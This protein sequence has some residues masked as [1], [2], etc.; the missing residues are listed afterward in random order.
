[1]LDH[2]AYPARRIAINLQFQARGSVSTYSGYLEHNYI[3][4]H[5]PQ[6]GPYKTPSRLF[7]T[8]VGII[9]NRLQLYFTEA[10]LIPGIKQG[11]PKVLLYF[12]LQKHE[13]MTVLV[14]HTKLL[15]LPFVL[16]CL[17]FTHQNHILEPN[18]IEDLSLHSRNQYSPYQKDHEE[19]IHLSERLGRYSPRAIGCKFF[20]EY[21]LTNNCYSRFLA[22]IRNSLSVSICH[23]IGTD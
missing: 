11:K 20:P 3:Y 1:M 13:L 7:N 19:T 15:I 18:P 16:R 8:P 14:R 4:R 23:E 5:S 6:S 10:R 21:Y 17:N 12:R 22:C 9:Q 2:G